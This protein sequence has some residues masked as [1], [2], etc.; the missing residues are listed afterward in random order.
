MET[1]RFPKRQF[2]LK[3]HGTESQK[4][5]IS[6]LGSSERAWLLGWKEGSDIDN[7]NPISQFVSTRNSKFKSWR[8]LAVTV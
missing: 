3:L 1:A 6:G 4:A 5:S 2:E 7:R 8:G